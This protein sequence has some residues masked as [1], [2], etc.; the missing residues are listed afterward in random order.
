[1]EKINTGTAP[2]ADMSG[3]RALVKPEIQSLPKYNPG[4]PEEVVR[5]RYNL[6]LV[7]RLASN[8]NPF[9]T[10][11]LAR[12]AVAASLG[13]LWKYSDPDSTE[14]RR[15]LSLTSGVA[16]Q[17][18]VVGNGSEDLICIICRACLAKGDRVVTVHPS[19]LLHE[20]YPLEQGADVVTVPMTEGLSF[21]THRIIT[22][23]EQGCKLL[24]FS[25]PSN[26]VG[27][28]LSGRN[29]AAICDSMPH[30][31]LI[32]IDEAYYEYAAREDSFPDSLALLKHYKN[33]HVILR[34]F[35]KAYGMAGL[36]IGYGFFSDPWL[37][38]QINKLR[39]P[40]NINILAQVAAL[41]ALGDKHHLT[42]TV[43]S[44]R[45]ERSRVINA[46]RRKGYLVADSYANFVFVDTGKDSLKAAERLLARGLIVKPWTAAGYERF[47]RITISG[48]K[49]ND[50]LLSLI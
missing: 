13:E 1:M 28:I 31:T 5:Q 3:L 39:T 2:P 10:S 17:N 8:E 30:D 18:I 22:E 24:I 35:S 50:L 14:V 37:A 41:S 46:L 48:K 4:L 6:E 32:V 25:N 40:F 23:L 19:F 33:P 27:S 11:P 36:R 38:E 20:I 29:L 12:Q 34:T 49:E 21:D 26:P 16:P 43:E 45:D 47:L 7:T 15:K 44:N 42:K 9:G